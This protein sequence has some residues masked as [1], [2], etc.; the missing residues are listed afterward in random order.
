MTRNI[1][2][3]LEAVRP[4]RLD[5]DTHDHEG[6]IRAIIDN[7]DP[8]PTDAAPR[9]RAHRGWLLSTGLAV[10]AAAAAV[11]VFVA[12]STSTPTPAPAGP[13]PGSQ[14]S[15]PSG[16]A[17]SAKD[18]L[19][20]AARTTLR[21]GKPPTAGTW[22]ASKREGAHVEEALMDGQK[23]TVLVRF[24]EEAWHS[25]RAGTPDY[26]VYQELG[27]APLT[28]AD[29]EIVERLGSPSEYRTGKKG[30]AAGKDGKP[31]QVEVTYSTKPGDAKISEQPYSPYLLP[32]Q[33][34]RWS[35]LATLPADPVRLKKLVGADAVH[36]D[37]TTVFVLAF[38]LYSSP[39]SKEVR[40]ALYTILSE[41]PGAGSVG[42]VRDAKGRLADTIT[43][44]G[45]QMWYLIDAK[46]GAPIGSEVH[47]K[48]DPQ[49]SVYD[50][51]I[52]DGF[53][54]SP[55]AR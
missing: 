24:R 22:W 48:R 10:T 18:V 43:F 20:A 4:A 34:L 29:A 16:P 15:P 50:L 31:E 40:A 55:P 26:Y 11:T 36:D 9:D 7:T 28:A 2:R 12:T 44:D 33:K 47:P 45:G 37:P 30:W 52:S 41:L 13:R 38:F 53:E 6:G 51:R 21:D 49:L 3:R 46:T 39:V 54:D 32:E 42:R 23:F 19:L 35:D 14:A 27:A 17:T 1:R 8:L 25:Q 5:P